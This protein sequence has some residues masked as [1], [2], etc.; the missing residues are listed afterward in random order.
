MGV[1]L[2]P[3][4]LSI[5]WVS[6]VLPTTCKFD[7]V[8]VLFVLTLGIVAAPIAVGLR[9]SK[10]PAYLSVELFTGGIFLIAFV[11]AVALRARMISSSSEVSKGQQELQRKENTL[12]AQD[13]LQRLLSVKRV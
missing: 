3:A 11:C 10:Q 2:L 9:S 1:Q 7:V 8:K 4:S 6:I 12:S 5:V 13:R